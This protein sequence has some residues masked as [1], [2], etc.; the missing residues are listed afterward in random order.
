M[1]AV[2]QT[3]QPVRTAKHATQRRISRKERARYRVLLQ[4]SACLAAGLVLAMGYLA[5]NARLTSLNYAYV[6]AQHERAALQAQTARLDEQLASLRSDD[7]LGAIALRLHMQDPQTFAL[8]TLPAPAQQT[9][10]THL[11]F[12]AGIATLFG[13]K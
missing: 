2:K 11:A 9:R 10:P 4:F 6:R 8:V 13:A 7:R 1:Y 5:M 12:L 3:A